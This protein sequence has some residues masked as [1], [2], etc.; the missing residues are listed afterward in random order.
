MN[1]Y[2]NLQA[3]TIMPTSAYD[4]IHTIMRV[5]LHMIASDHAYDNAYEH[6]QASTHAEK[7]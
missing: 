7:D 1:T 5:R 3:H 4:F 6:S 2:K